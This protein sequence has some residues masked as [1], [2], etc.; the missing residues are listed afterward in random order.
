M[1]VSRP[2]SDS[3]VSGVCAFLEAK[4]CPV[5]AVAN[6]LRGV[7]SDSAYLLSVLKT[8]SGPI[9]PV[10]HSYAGF[11]ISSA[12]AA[13]PE[14]KALVYVAACIPEKGESPAELTY[15]FPGSQLTGSN[16]LTRPEPGGTDIYINPADF[17][18]VYAGGLSPEQT[19]P[20][21][22]ATVNPPASVPKWEIVALHDN[23]IPTKA[24]FSM[25]QRACAR[26]VTADSAMTSRPPP[27]RWWTA[28]SSRRRAP[29]ARP[30]GPA[31][32]AAPSAPG[33]AIRPA[34]GRRRRVRSRRRRRPSPRR[35]P[36]TRRPGV[37]RSW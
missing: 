25:A 18:S 9:V 11:L 31:P 13:D 8:I 4:G 22:P 21:E 23:A 14:V 6:P 36:G 34:R 1:R 29:P 16:L 28:S 27:R 32:P 26:G 35:P 24:E 12:A 19:A 10:G 5:V 37:R 7:A 15:K 17:S 33:G 20:A 3:R 30:A 2:E